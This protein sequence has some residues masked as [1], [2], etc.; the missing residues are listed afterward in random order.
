MANIIGVFCHIFEINFSIGECYLYIGGGYF[1]ISI[2]LYLLV[3]DERAT[4]LVKI[5]NFRLQG[6]VKVVG[7]R[8][9]G[10]LY[11]LSENLS[12]PM[13]VSTVERTYQKLPVNHYTGR[14]KVKKI[15]FQ[16][17]IVKAI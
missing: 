16:D 1:C 17:H 5:A 14:E 7:G 8:I 12:D 13:G 15:P 10:T 11:S 4:F 9:L 3:G 2:F 6:S